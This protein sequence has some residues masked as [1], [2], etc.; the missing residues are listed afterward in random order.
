VELAVS[1]RTSDIKD[2]INKHSLCLSARASIDKNDPLMGVQYL[3]FALVL[4]GLVWASR[5][6]IGRFL[7]LISHFSAR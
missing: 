5:H 3:G 7:K 1:F 6:R 4:S 2:M